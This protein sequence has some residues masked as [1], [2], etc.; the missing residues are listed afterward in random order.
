M[1]LF[2]LPSPSA[3]LSSFASAG[4]CFLA[5]FGTIHIHVLVF[6]PFAFSFLVFICFCGSLLLGLFR[7]HPHPCP[8]FRSLRLQLPCLHLL[9]REPASWPF[10]APSTSMS[11]FSLP[12][13]SASLS[14]FA[15]A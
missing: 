12:S 11:L 1:S 4:A 13:P 7:H 15:S 6:A 10:S 2:S 8:C 3:S 9:L 5:F 14:S